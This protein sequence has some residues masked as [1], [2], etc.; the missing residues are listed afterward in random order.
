MPTPTEVRRQL[1]KKAF[2]DDAIRVKHVKLCS[3]LGNGRT[4]IYDERIGQ[5]FS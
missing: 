3:E 5:P 4:D 1:T 2:C